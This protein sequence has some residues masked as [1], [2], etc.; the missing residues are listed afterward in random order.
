M[1]QTM[2]GI[3]FD[4][5]ARRIVLVNPSLPLS[6]GR[7]VVRNLTLAQ[8][9]IDFAISQ[10]GKAVSLQVLRTRGDLQISLLFDANAERQLNF[11]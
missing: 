9:S 3:Q 10:E 6:A 4:P 5:A 1:L 8:A 2:L 11:A 7:V